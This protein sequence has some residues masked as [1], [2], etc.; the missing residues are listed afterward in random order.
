METKTGNRNEYDEYVYMGTYEN[1]SKACNHVHNYNE[2]QHHIDNN[3]VYYQESYE[4]ILPS[5]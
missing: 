3:D 2:H 5:K 1:C 4:T